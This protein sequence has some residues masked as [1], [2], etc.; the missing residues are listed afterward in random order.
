MGEASGTESGT[1]AP[2]PICA[3]PSRA[4][5]SSSIT[6]A[7]NGPSWAWRKWPRLRTPTPRPGEAKLIVVDV[8]PRGLLPRPVTLAEIKADPLFAGWELV[9]LPRL[10]V[11]PV[12]S[13]YWQAVLELANLPGG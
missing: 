11:M 13:Q 7:R 4:I 6:P 10:S 2:S 3:A 5:P 8:V 9:R 12:P 1:R